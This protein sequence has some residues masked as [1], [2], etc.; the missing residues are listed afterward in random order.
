[1]KALLILLLAVSIAAYAHSN[2]L[3]HLGQPFVPAG[4]GTD[5]IVCS[6]P[7]DFATLQNGLGC[8]S[9]NSWM[10]ADDIEMTTCYYFHTVLTWMLFTGSGATQYNFAVYEDNGSGPG[11]TQF[12]SYIETNITNID[13]GLSNWGYALYESVCVF[14]T[15]VFL[16][17]STKYW[18]SLQTESSTTDYWLCTDQKW[19]DET[20][21]SGDNG[22]SWTSST[23]E[24]GAPYE[25]F[26]IMHAIIPSLG[27]CTWG[28]IKAVF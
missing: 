27:R 5:D 12:C 3:G 16:S 24:F 17:G 1:M 4:P 19:A 21:W 6:Q 8:N 23:V 22:S 28:E 26:I 11:S 14:G 2:Q 25:Q 18:F 15:Q 20:Y 13:T 9:A 10:V 7:F